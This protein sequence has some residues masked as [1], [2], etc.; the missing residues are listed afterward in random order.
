MERYVRY[1]IFLILIFCSCRTEEPKPSKPVLVGYET[2][3]VF[4]Y[5]PSER[6]RITWTQDKDA[7]PDI[8]VVTQQGWE[9]KDVKD[10]TMQAKLTL[11]GIKIFWDNYQITVEEIPIE[12]KEYTLQRP[13][14]K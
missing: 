11:E 10:K 14:Y 6:E 4:V 1:S 2:K 9:I 5:D 3:V 7:I 8:N 12:G 13:I